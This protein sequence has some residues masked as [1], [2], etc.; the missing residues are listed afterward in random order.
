MIILQSGLSFSSEDY[1]LAII[2]MI[3]GVVFIV[4]QLISWLNW[5][6]IVKMTIWWNKHVYKRH[7][8]PYQGP[9]D[10]IKRL[11]HIYGIFLFILG[12][13]LIGFGVMIFVISI[14]GNN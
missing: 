10:N 8:E 2:C 4:Y 9:S 6:L 11:S 7:K 1:L 12:L 5:D 3:F 14:I 13:G